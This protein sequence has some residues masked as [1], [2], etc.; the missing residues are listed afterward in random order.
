MT[1]TYG[2]YSKSIPE[3]RKMAEVGNNEGLKENR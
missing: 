1:D 2:E 3:R